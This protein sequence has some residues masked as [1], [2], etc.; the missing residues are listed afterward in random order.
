MRKKLIEIILFTVITFGLPILANLI[1]EILSG[2]ITMQMIMK[3]VYF[4][5][6]LSIIYILKEIRKNYE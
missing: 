2:I 3:C 4:G 6:G 1:V 5:L